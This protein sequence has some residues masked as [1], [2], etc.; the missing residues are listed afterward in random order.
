VRTSLQHR[1]ALLQLDKHLAQRGIPT[2]LVPEGDQA[3]YDTL[4]V[5]LGDGETQ[6]WRLELSFLPGLEDELDEVSILQCFAP[7]VDLTES[8]GLSALHELILLINPK[9]PLGSFGIITAPPLVFWKHN[10]LLTNEQPQSNATLVSELV[11]LAGY[12]LSLFT[13]ALTRVATG[14]SDVATA[15]QDPRFAHVYR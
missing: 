7:V 3:P 4:L 2:H 15:M 13:G 8:P 14:E 6:S 5:G 1:N 11:M 10:A 9:L 12:L